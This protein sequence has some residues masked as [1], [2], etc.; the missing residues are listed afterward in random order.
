MSRVG[1]VL[2]FDNTV[3]IVVRGRIYAGGS[4]SQPIIMKKR[5]EM[6]PYANITWMRLSGGDS[7]MEGVL[8][9]NVTGDWSAVCKKVWQLPDLFV[10]RDVV[11]DD[12]SAEYTKS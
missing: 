10:Q 4:S 7:E 12:W 1:S 5:V 2:E 11:D 3:G 8:E 9:L 6:N